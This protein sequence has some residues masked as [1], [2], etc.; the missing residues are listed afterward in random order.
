MQ[1]LTLIVWLLLYGILLFALC[2]TYSQ[3]TDTL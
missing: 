2:Y 1:I 3:G